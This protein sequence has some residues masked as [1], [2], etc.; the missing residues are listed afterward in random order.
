VN[1]SRI[2]ALTALLA[3]F[4]IPGAAQAGFT[5]CRLEYE[6]HA[7][8]VFYK[9][10]TG[11]GTVTCENGESANVTLQFH[12]GGITFGVSDLNGVVRF[13]QVRDVS[14]VVGA[15]FTVE[16]HAGLSRSVEGRA[17]TRGP[18]WISQSG[19]GRGFDL[20]FAFGALSIRRN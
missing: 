4:A 16:G 10:V 12:G 7:W 11:T 18:V 15:Y 17:G 8:S 5:A 3:V 9:N 19:K 2:F 20:G 6:T 1:T 13:S 14:E